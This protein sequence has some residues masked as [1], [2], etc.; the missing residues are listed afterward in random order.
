M[1]SASVDSVLVNG[2]F[3]LNPHRREI[4]RG[5]A[6]ILKPEAEVFGAELIVNTTLSKS[7]RELVL[8]NRRSQG[9]GCITGGV[10]RG[11]ISRVQ[12]RALVTKRKDQESSRGR[13][14]IQRSSMNS[15]VRQLT[16]LPN[17]A[18]LTTTGSEW[19]QHRLTSLR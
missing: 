6:Q 12:N 15:S 9:C 17:L 14:R 18:E 4:F 13:G 5:L 11:W 1:T 19:A 8:V 10:S 3:N 7:D 16:R 2:I